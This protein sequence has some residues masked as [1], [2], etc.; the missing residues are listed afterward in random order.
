MH[1]FCIWSNC[2]RFSDHYASLGCQAENLFVYIFWTRS[3]HVLEVAPAQGSK[4]EIGGSADL[5]ISE[6]A[7]TKAEQQGERT[8]AISI[9]E[10]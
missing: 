6:L 10:P 5:K 8:H 1:V 9:P 2:V 4:G 7:E 3:F